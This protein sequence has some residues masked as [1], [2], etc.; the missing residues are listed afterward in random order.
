[1]VNT[2]QRVHPTGT[3]LVAIYVVLTIASVAVLVVLSAI[4]SPQATD[5][6]WGHAVITALFCVLLPLR[7]RAARRGRPGAVR[8]V[9]IIAL[10]L[11]VVNAVEAALSS[12][13]PFWMRLEML[14]VVI[15]MALLAAVSSRGSSPR[16]AASSGSAVR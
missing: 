1:M 5:A 11:L 4:G 13:F 10:A 8:A 7:M 3:T 6:A 16:E 14:A 12:T 9:R 15:I 2:T